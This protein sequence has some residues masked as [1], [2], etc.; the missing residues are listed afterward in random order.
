MLFYGPHGALTPD[1][2]LVLETAAWRERLFAMRAEPP[3]LALP[4]ADRAGSPDAIT[5]RH[6]PRA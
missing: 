3:R 5:R 4:A 2:D 6:D 1:G